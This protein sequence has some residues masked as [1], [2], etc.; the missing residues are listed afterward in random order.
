MVGRRSGQT[1]RGLIDH[2]RLI[3]DADLSFPIFLAAN[4][5][6]MDGRQELRY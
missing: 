3:D 5:E 1:W 4:G 6:V 2:I